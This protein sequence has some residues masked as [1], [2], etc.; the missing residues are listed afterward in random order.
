[1]EG[2]YF[3][4]QLGNSR[5]LNE[6][7]KAVT[8]PL[9]VAG[10]K[11]E[12]VHYPAINPDLPTLV[13]LHEGL[14]CVSMWR[15]FPQRV[16]EA[17]GLGALVYS[18]C[19]YGQSDPCELPRPL[20]YLEREALDTL[21]LVLAK[22]GIGAHFLIGHSDGG[23]IALV[24]AGNAPGDNLKGVITMAPHV[25]C[26]SLSV[27]SIASAREAFLHGELRSKLE[28]R[29]GKNVDCAFWG[30]NEAWLDPAFLNWDIT[31]Y[32]PE[33]CAPQL[34]IQGGKDEF[35]TTAQLELI[36]R[37]SGGAVEL[38]VLDEGGHACYRDQPEKCIELVADFIA[39]RN[40]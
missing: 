1:M 24:Y 32:L 9:T 18:R 38:R 14:G 13:F 7:M 3:L 37:H 16:C 36:E 26:E 21:P 33:I 23:S 8:G 2:R 19:G 20:D 5:D 12:A 17:T 28:K 22:A 6:Q 39:A 4:T 35:G 29:H 30:W 40:R 15:D 31:H 11:L 34:V 10:I 25:M 27:K